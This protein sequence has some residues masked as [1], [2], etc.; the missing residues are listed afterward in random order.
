MRP[1]PKP[2]PVPPWSDLRPEARRRLVLLWSELLQRQ[3]PA[4]RGPV[5]A[6]GEPCHER[7]LGPHAIVYVR[8]STPRQVPANRESTRRR[9]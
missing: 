9:Y 2:S 6:P 4:A 8:Q 1:T 7:H 5:S 3:L